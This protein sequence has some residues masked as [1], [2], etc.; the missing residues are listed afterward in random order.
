ML[1]LMLLLVM[2][3]KIKDL[4]S[5]KTKA[6]LLAIVKIYLIENIKIAKNKKI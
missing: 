5:M 1:Y 4:K 3:G 2:N 6:N